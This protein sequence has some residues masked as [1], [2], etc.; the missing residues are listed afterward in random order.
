M[1]PIDHLVVE[2]ILTW[3]PEYDE[4]DREK[5]EAIT[6]RYLLTMHSGLELNEWSRS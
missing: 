1:E 2:N 3:Y 4:P 6:L 5:K